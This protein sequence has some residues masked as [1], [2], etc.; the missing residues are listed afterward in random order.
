M[1]VFLASLLFFFNVFAG[2]DKNISLII[3]TSIAPIVAAE[4]VGSS[5][6]GVSDDSKINLKITYNGTN[7]VD[8]ILTSKNNWELS[9]TDTS[10]RI[11]YYCVCENSPVKDGR[12]FLPFSKFVDCCC[13]LHL[14]FEY[15]EQ[16]FDVPIGEYND[17]IEIAIFESKL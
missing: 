6:V 14:S 8:V 1:K 2:N 16:D 11:P 13:N 3:S 7:G 9:K 17:T 15:T 10:S 5:V 4:I 12:I